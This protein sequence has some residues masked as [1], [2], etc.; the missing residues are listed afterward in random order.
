[1]NKN[2]LSSVQDSVSDLLSEGLSRAIEVE[3]VDTRCAPIEPVFGAASRRSAEP[4]Q[5]SGEDYHDTASLVQE[6]ASQ[7][8]QSIFDSLDQLQVRLR[9]AEQLAKLFDQATASL[10]RTDQKPD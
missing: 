7:M 9:G 5:T 6:D 8:L 2:R 3:S 1:M 10:R 4:G